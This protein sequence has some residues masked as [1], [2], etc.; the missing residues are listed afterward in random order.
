MPVCPRWSRK[1][2]GIVC[3]MTGKFNEIFWDPAVIHPGYVIIRGR[4]EV[5]LMYWLQGKWF[6]NIWLWRPATLCGHYR[7]LVDS[8]GNPPGAGGGGRAV[9]FERSHESYPGLVK[10]FTNITTKLITLLVYTVQCNTNRMATWYTSCLKSVFR[11]VIFTYFSF[12]LELIDL[13]IS[14]P[15]QTYHSRV[16]YGN[17]SNALCYT[18]SGVWFVTIHAHISQAK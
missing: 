4:C 6:G 16:L 1:I 8:A 11:W 13:Q 3:H 5:Y 18:H 9:L 10:I 12:F 15:Q 2:P 14:V 17:V 7:H